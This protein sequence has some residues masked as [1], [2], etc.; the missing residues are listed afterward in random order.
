MYGHTPNAFIFSLCNSQPGL[1]P[2]KSMVKDRSK[3]IY[4]NL[5]YGPTFGGA[6]G[7]TLH[8]IKIAHNAGSVWGSYT[9]FGTAYNLPPGV[10]TNPQNIL[11]GSKD[12]NPSE[13]EVFYLH[14]SAQSVAP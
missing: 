9:A 14:G 3:A 4:K 10:N 7:T 12:F 11:A 1:G 6:N 13:L 2:F 5:G 8:D